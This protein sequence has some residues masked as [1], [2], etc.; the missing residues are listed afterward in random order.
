M[1]RERFWLLVVVFLCAGLAACGGDRAEPLAI[2]LHAQDIKFDVNTLTVKAGQPVELTYINE[3]RIDHTFKI[4]GLVEDQKV[5]PG[6]THVFTFTAKRPGVYQ[7]V[8]AIPGHDKA[9]MVGTLIV[10]P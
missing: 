9:G 2:A 6:A 3:G 7:Y 8:C 5:R 1:Q 4:D 10:E